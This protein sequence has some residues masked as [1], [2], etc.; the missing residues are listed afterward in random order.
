MGELQKS[1]DILIEGIAAGKRSLSEDHLGVLMGCRELARTYSR[2]GRLDEAV[3]LIITTIEK[4]KIFQGSEHPDYATV[5][6]SLGKVWEKKQE[7]AK[8]INAYQV[9]LEAT[10]KRLT[11]E[12][13]LYKII[14]DRII[15]L[16]EG[17]HSNDYKEATEN[18]SV[19]NGGEDLRIKRLHN[20][21]TW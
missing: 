6:W 10:E 1:E 18:G 16:T 8:A 21:Q 13:P 11:T 20:T 12:H 2:Q 19:T 15:L 9:V 5:M 17:A 4:M 14:S 7:Q 3:K